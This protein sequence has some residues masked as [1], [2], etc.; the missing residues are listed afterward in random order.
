L[1]DQGKRARSMHLKKARQKVPHE[2]ADYPRSEAQAPRICD[3]PI[4]ASDHRAGI[5]VAENGGGDGR[6]SSADWKK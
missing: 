5:W 3:E 4:A 2:R 1:G 6:S